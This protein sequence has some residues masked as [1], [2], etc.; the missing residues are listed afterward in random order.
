MLRYALPE[1]RLPKAVLDKEIELIERLGVQFQFNVNGRR[2]DHAQ[3]PGPPVRRRLPG[4]RHLEGSL[5]LPARHRAHGRDPG[6]A[7]P[8]GRVARRDGP[9]RQEGGRDRRRQRRHR[10]RAHGSPAGR[11]RDHRLPPRAQGHAGHPRGD[12]GGRARGGEARLPRRAAP[13]RRRQ[14]RPGARDRGR[15]DQARRV[16][17]LGPPA[18][19]ADRRG[20]P[21]RVRHR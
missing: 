13:H 10:L 6:A 5:G 15:Q 8:G 18:A 20:D 4:H 19:R 2:G 12:R 16:R 1:Y 11:R 21:D 14:E 17:H 9:G 7:L 3:R